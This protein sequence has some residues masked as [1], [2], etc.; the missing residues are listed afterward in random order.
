MW[1]PSV[2]ALWKSRSERGSASKPASPRRQGFRPRLET[3][4]DRAQRR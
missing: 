4:E 3:L 1:S 2:F